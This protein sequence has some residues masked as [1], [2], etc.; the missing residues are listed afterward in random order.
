MEYLLPF[1]HAA[2]EWFSHPIPRYLS[3]A[4]T[5]TLSEAESE[6][7]RLRH[8]RYTEDN[9]ISGYFQVLFQS[10]AIEHNHTSKTADP[11]NSHPNATT[12]Y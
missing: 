6:A 8:S 10:S 9:K 11:G 12:L 4:E 3:P 1:T 5:D 2:R 7:T